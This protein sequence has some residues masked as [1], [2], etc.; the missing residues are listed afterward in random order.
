VGVPPPHAAINKTHRASAA[1]VKIMSNNRTLTRLTIY[2]LLH[3]RCTRTARPARGGP[4]IPLFLLSAKAARPESAR[5]ARDHRAADTGHRIQA[6]SGRLEQA[7][8]SH[9]EQLLPRCPATLR[10]LRDAPHPPLPGLVG[11]RYPCYT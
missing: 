10:R 2:P 1:N 6:R 9:P 7:A 5:C 8:S 11:K 4:S 3:R